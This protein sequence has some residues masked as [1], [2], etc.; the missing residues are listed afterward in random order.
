MFNSSNPIS[1]KKLTFLLL[2]FLFAGTT[3]LTSCSKKSDTTTPPTIQLVSGPG[4]ITTD[5]TVNSGSHVSFKISASA[6]S[7]KLDKF[8]VQS[9][10][11]LCTISRSYCRTA[12]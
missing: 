5:V 3:L 7:G 12:A 11:Q 9:A 2:V 8:L 4:L 6:S 10:L 1:M